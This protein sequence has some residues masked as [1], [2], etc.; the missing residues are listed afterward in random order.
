MRT[1]ADSATSSTVDEED[2]STAVDA[3]LVA[4][5]VDVED[6]LS[7]RVDAVAAVGVAFT[8]ALVVGE[9]VVVAPVAVVDIL[10]KLRNISE[11]KA[12]A[13]AEDDDEEDGNVEGDDN[14]GRN[15]NVDADGVVDTSFF[16]VKLGS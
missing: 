11:N 5:S 8:A 1:T 13:K 3:D 2:D 14:A 6:A 10:H 7:V 12:N 16:F 4:V 9:V 15:G